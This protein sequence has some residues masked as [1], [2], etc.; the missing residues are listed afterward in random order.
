MRV[1]CSVVVEIKTLKL[2]VLSY[3]IL[4]IGFQKTLAGALLKLGIKKFQNLHL[5]L[6]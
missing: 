6:Q 4:R 3:N 5:G 2:I 1:A